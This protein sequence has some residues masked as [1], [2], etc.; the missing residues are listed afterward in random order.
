MHFEIHN[1]FTHSIHTH[2]RTQYEHS[3]AMFV[4]G[5]NGISSCGSIFNVLF[6]DS[7]YVHSQYN[8]YSCVN[9]IIYNKISVSRVVCR[10]QVPIQVTLHVF[11]CLNGQCVRFSVADSFVT[12]QFSINFQSNWFTEGELPFFERCL[13][14]WIELVG[15]GT[16]ETGFISILEESSLRELTHANPFP[17]FKWL[18]VS[19]R[20]QSK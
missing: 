19:D 17:S 9:V 3:T 2:T 7:H 12:V 15:Q 20:L 4:D 6:N 8:V 1:Q 16:D 5:F 18:K 10:F 14:F 13:P 11:Y